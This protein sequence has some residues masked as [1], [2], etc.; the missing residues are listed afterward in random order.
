MSNPALEYITDLG[1]AIDVAGLLSDYTLGLVKYRVAGEA[2]DVA[3][4]KLKAAIDNHLDGDDA[5]PIRRTFEA[6][7]LARSDAG[8]ALSQIPSLDDV[9]KAAASIAA[10]ERR[11]S[12][13]PGR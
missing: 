5:G 12:S 11:L 13:E 9:L 4:A 6:Y 2:A 8:Q 1:T 7:T 10:I 3:F